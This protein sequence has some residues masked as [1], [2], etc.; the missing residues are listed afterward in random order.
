MECTS[1]RGQGYQQ[2][3]LETP[4]PNTGVSDLFSQ[5]QWKAFLALRRGYQ[6]YQDF[7]SVR[8]LAHLRFVRWLSQT[9]RVA[10]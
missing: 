4:L 8:E 2:L 5:G 7:F 3:P 1:A 10:A 6:E 9:G